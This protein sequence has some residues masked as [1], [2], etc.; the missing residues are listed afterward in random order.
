MDLSVFA[1]ESFYL[2][3]IG[4]PEDNTLRVV[5]AETRLAE[6][7]KDENLI[8]ATPIVPA[9]DVDVIEIT[10]R[11]YIAYAVLNESFTTGD[12]NNV[13]K[14]MLERRKS[15]AFLDYVTQDTFA[16]ADY[17]GPFEHWELMCLNHIVHVAC[18]S[19]P[20]FKRIPAEPEWFSRAGPKNYRR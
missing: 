7:I 8:S 18:A 3:E 15:S 16:S 12:P 2:L 20:A 13:P 10:W 11:E 17:P 14:S 19:P 6:P 1:R 9:T 4:E 5:V